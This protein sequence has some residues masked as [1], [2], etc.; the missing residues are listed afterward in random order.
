VAEGRLEVRVRQVGEA[1]GF[2]HDLGEDFRGVHWGRLAVVRKVEGG[3]GHLPLGVQRPTERA[4][5]DERLE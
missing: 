4:G 2:G 5:P 1:L 3:E